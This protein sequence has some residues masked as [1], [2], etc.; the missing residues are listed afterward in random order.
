M[1]L[2]FYIF[3][4]IYFIYLRFA[5]RVINSKLSY[6]YFIF[7]IKARVK[8]YNRIKILLRFII[9]PRFRAIRSSLRILISNINEINYIK[10]KRKGYFNNISELDYIRIEYNK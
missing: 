10:T 3:I 8:I 1:R 9:R 6:Y 2:T 7:S 5:I 4:I